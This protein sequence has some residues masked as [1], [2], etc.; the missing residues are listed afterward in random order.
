MASVA[1]AGLEEI[2]EYLLPCWIPWAL[3]RWMWNMVQLGREVRSRTEYI[4]GTDRHLF[5]NMSVWDSR[6]NLYHY[7]PGSALS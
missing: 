6:H 7:L 1:A 2:L 4:L 3:D 5:S